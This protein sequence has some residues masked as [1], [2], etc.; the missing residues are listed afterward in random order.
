MKIIRHI[1]QNNNSYIIYPGIFV[2]AHLTNKNKIKLYSDF[3][4]K[5]K[6]NISNYI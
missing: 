5:Y 4:S 3:Y 6:I 1:Q 2:N